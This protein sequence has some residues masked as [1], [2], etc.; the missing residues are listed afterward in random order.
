ME[1]GGLGPDD[2]G[3]ASV[4]RC[5]VWSCVP[6]PGWG[7]VLVG[8]STWRPPSFY[9]MHMRERTTPLYI[10]RG[11][12]RR[13]PPVDTGTRTGPMGLFPVSFSVQLSVEHCLYTARPASSERRHGYV[14]GRSPREKRLARQPLPLPLRPLRCPL[15][16][17]F[18]PATHLP[19]AVLHRRHRLRC[20]CGKAQRWHRLHQHRSWAC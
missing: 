11:V 14:C 5:P 3:L 2:G 10:H 6:G 7:G 16:M 20:R 12:A 15:G 9:I 13:P 19:P 1:V 8:V 17:D 18:V 4:G